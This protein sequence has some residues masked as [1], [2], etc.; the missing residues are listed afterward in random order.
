MTAAVVDV[1]EVARKMAAEAPR[2]STGRIEKLRGLIG[3]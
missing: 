2:L 1:R 3:R